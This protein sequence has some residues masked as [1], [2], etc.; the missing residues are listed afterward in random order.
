MN[1]EIENKIEATLYGVCVILLL[2]VVSLPTTGYSRVYSEKDKL[3]MK[4]RAAVIPDTNVFP[5]GSLRFPAAAQKP[6]STQ[7]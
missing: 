6:A 5:V 2:L 4:H 3:A 1:R 7:L